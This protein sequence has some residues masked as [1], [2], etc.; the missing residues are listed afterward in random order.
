ML[1]IIE[2]TFSR[3][4]IGYTRQLSQRCY[5]IIVVTMTTKYYR[6]HILLLCP[7]FETLF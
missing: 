5:Y 6:V 3:Y 7:H 2:E 1:P 4:T